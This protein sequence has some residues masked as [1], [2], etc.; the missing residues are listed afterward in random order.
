MRSR[1]LVLAL[2]LAAP[3]FAQEAPPLPVTRS[4]YVLD[5]PFLHFGALDLDAPQP[6]RLVVDVDGA[7][8]NTFSHT[9]HAAG[10]QREFMTEGQAF[11]LWQAQKLHE[12]HPQDT[13]DFIDAEITRVALV[14]RV[15]LTPSLTASV[16]VPWISFTALHLDRAIEDFH[17]AVGLKDFQRDIF[18]NGRFQIVRQRP[19]G[20]LEFDDATPSAGLG[21][22]T[23]RLTYRTTL[24][25][26]TR[27]GAELAVKAPT[28]SAD[29]FRSSGSWDVGLLA[30][31]EHRFFSSRRL[32]LH[33]EAALVEPGRY[34]GERATTI[35][36]VSLFT[37][38][39]LGADVKVGRKRWFSVSVVR[40]DSPF[41]KDPVGDGARASLEFVFGV[42]RELSSHARASLSLTENLP[43]AG[44]A[45][46]VA[47]LLGVT[48]H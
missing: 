23:G 36:D 18:P 1:P 2:L 9:W 20:A 15:G 29:D 7:Y 3:A 19:F 48:V 12:R 34:R 11:P 31:A 13:I 10:I 46:D 43:S 30:G 39:L 5:V 16:E 21:D 26:A 44:D 41:H 8:A 33:L 37:R 47:V 17:K 24:S 38:V 4:L 14:G 27:W 25:D 45:A 6:G 35:R 40:E 32:G 28:G 42:V 22:V